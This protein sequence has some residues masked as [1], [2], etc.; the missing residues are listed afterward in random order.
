M[1]NVKLSFFILIVGIFLNSAAQAQT[2]QRVYQCRTYEFA[3]LQ[4]MNKNELSQLFCKNNA[5]IE[6]GKILLKN[7]EDFYENTRQLK[8]KFIMSASRSQLDSLQTDMDDAM[9]RAKNF[10]DQ[11]KMCAEE[12]ERVLRIIKKGNE[13][14]EAPKCDETSK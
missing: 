8:M 5:S 12:N 3:E 11:A 10:S 14:I 1:K 6:N 4:T 13:K 2:G 9:K 7:A